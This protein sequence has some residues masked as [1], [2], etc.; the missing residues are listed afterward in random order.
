[1]YSAVRPVTKHGIKQCL[2][3]RTLALDKGIRDPCKQETAFRSFDRRLEYVIH[4][5]RHAGFTNEKQVSMSLCS[6]YNGNIYV[7]LHTKKYILHVFVKNEY[8]DDGESRLP[9][10][11]RRYAEDDLDEG[12]LWHS[13]RFEELTDKIVDMFYERA[14]RLQNL[15]SCGCGRPTTQPE[16]LCLECMMTSSECTEDTEE[17]EC[18]ICLQDIHSHHEIRMPCCKISV[19]K[20]C[21]LQHNSSKCCHCRRS[22]PYGFLIDD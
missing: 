10:Y 19:H 17:A 13:Q 20:G 8:D 5:T 4:C 12:G 15:T 18:L 2:K 6:S 3:A 9:A 22:L 14:I 16:G 21:L 1:M 11:A 7:A